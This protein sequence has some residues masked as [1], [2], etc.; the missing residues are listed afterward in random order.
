MHFVR[1]VSLLD[2]GVSEI[3]VCLIN[4]VSTRHLACP[5]PNLQDENAHHHVITWE[6]LRSLPCTGAMGGLYR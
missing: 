1:P 2:G 3:H 5:L 4:K 6:L